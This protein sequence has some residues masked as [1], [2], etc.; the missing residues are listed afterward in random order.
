MFLFLDGVISGHFF[1]LRFSSTKKP[2]ID[3]SEL[4]NGDGIYILLYKE[5]CRHHVYLN[6]I[7]I[8]WCNLQYGIQ[9]SEKRRQFYFLK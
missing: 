3:I 2:S 4:S 9:L 6:L 5:A 7:C 8:V 1:F